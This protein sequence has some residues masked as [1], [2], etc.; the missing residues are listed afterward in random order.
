MSS[1]RALAWELT[2]GSGI[3]IAFVALKEGRMTARGTALR[4]AP[5]P[6]RLDYELDT[7]ESFATRSLHVRSEGA[8]W[9]RVLHLERK[10][11][12]GWSVEVTQRGDVD[13][14]EGGGDAAAFEDALDCDLGLSPL[15]N[16]MPVL[17]HG[18]LG[19][20][21]PLEFRMAWVSVPDLA[22]H[23]SHQG[24]EHI[25]SLEDGA[26]VRYRSLDGTFVADIS[27]DA[28][29]FVVDYPGLARRIP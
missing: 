24:Y 6:Y 10:A 9:D 19:G 14:P 1:D 20:G 13:L 22:V 28:H 27:F 16:S 18:L 25:R 26:V 7:A 2:E 5:I 8:G 4:S 29:G 21:G 23:A 15:T 11:D 3:E 12:G 17:R